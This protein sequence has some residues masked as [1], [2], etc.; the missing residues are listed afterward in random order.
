MQHAS[1]VR[2]HAPTVAADAVAPDRERSVKESVKALRTGLRRAGQLAAEG[3]GDRRRWSST[4]TACRSR[5]WGTAGQRVERLLSPAHLPDPHGHDAARRPLFIGDS[6][7]VYQATSVLLRCRRRGAERA[8]V[9]AP[10]RSS[11]AG[12]LIFRLDAAGDPR[13]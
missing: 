4:S 11:F 9:S 5:S 7:R 6:Y 1:Y 3:M 12:P 13:D 10:A 8:C 2:A